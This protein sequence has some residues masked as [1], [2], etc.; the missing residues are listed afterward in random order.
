MNYQEFLISADVTVKSAMQAIDS[1]SPQIVFVVE[2][3]KLI[4]SLTDGD[5]RR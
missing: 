1:V 5:I 2:D 4:A 3:N